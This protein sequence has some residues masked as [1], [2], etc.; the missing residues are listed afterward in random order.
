MMR[1]KSRQ[2]L[3]AMI[4]EQLKKC[5]NVTRTRQNVNQVKRKQIKVKQSQ[6]IK[7]FWLKFES[8]CDCLRSI[9]QVA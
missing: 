7:T 6:W 4:N 5:E 1:I 8:C 9:I 3:F 2:L